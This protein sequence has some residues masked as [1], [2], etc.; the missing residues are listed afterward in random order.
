MISGSN[1]RRRFRATGDRT[2]LA[3]GPHRCS[4]PRRSRPVDPRFFD[5]E[6][7]IPDFSAVS[8]DVAM[9][10]LRQ[11]RKDACTDHGTECTGFRGDVIAA[12]HADYDYARAV[13][14]GTVDR[15]PR[16]I[17]RYTGA[18][19]VAAAVRF[20]RNR[21]LEI[22]VRGGGHNVAGTAVCDDGIVIDLSA[23]RAVGR[24]CRTHGPGTGR[25]PVGRRRPRDPGPRP[26]H[27]RRIVGHTGVGG[28]SLG[29]GIGWLIASTGSPSTTSCRP[30]W[31]PRGRH[32]QR[33]R[34]APRSVLG[35][36]WRRRNF[37]VVS[38][39]RSRCTRTVRLS[40]PG[41][42]S[43]RPRTPPMS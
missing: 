10:R 27:H 40:L 13:W 24:P 21:D 39:F 18:A 6:V 37:G 43:G 5:F 32:L 17:A 1:A 8:G 12:E 38:S 23:M 25:R 2:V 11:R 4:V 41:L 26:G 34:R 19:D 7:H 20:A 28:L 14:N 15:R 30:R 3:V 22:A 29:G 9:G 31:S 16:L 36:A 33:G 42:S 35:A